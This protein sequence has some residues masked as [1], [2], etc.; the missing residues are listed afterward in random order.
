MCLRCTRREMLKTSGMA[1]PFMAGFLSSADGATAKRPLPVV[2]LDFLGK[3]MSLER[4][5]E[6]SEMDPVPW[7]LRAASTYHRITV[8]HAGAF[9]EPD[10]SRDRV[11]YILDGIMLEHRNRNYGDMGYHFVVDFAGRVWECRSLAYEGA[12]TSGQNEGNIGIMLLGN[13]EEQE[14]PADQ[15]DALGLAVERLRDRYRIKQHRIYGHRDLAQSLCPGK[16]LYPS[17][18]GLRQGDHAAT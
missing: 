12:H 15:L 16:K 13:F 1:L 11:A 9:H 2:D 7:R 5:A 10:A 17:I 6:W 18:E 4:R 3:E 14:P 8:H